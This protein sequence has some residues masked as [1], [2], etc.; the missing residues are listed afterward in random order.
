MPEITSLRHLKVPFETIWLDGH[1]PSIYMD[2]VVKEL[3]K[4]YKL[5]VNSVMLIL[6]IFTG[7]LYTLYVIP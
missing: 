4:S 6:V 2:G 3:I 1:F 5:V 7:A